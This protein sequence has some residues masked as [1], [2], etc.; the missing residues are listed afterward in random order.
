[1]RPPVWLMRQ[2]GRADPEY[3]ILREKTPLELETL[4]RHPDLAAQISLLPKRWGVDAIIFFQD[5]LT[6]LS[7]MGAPFIFRPG[8]QST[9][10]IRDNGDLDALRLFDMDEKL[11]FIADIFHR[12]RN[13]VGESLPVLGFA[14][15][16]L[17]LL[18]FIMEGESPSPTLRKTRLLLQEH[19][20]AARQALERLATMT[21]EYLAYQIR[22]GADAIQLFE[23]AAHCFS[24]EEYVEWG[25]PCQQ[26][27]FDALREKAPCIFFA[28][29]EQRSIPVHVLAASGADILSLPPTISIAEARRELGA[30][31]LVQGNLSNQVLAKGTREEIARQTHDCLCEGNGCG[32]IFNLGHGLLPDTPF[33]N[34]LFLM[35]LIKKYR[36]SAVAGGGNKGFIG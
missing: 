32:H 17:T 1:M 24:L 6:P 20:Q 2:A 33:E 26:C 7:G 11:P 10:P 23:S 31:R 36:G 25:L 21:I 9:A 22:S 5:I 18:A 12:I 14:G 8:P 16:P 27:I 3:R 35:E 29:Q 4:F 30:A 15:A 28:R 19:P 34:I 13:E